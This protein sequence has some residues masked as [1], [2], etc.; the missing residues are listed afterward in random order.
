MEGADFE[1][2]GQPPSTDRRP[3]IAPDRG[4]QHLA[5]TVFRQVF[6]SEASRTFL[7]G[8]SCHHL[9]LNFSK[10]LIDSLP[11]SGLSRGPRNMLAGAKPSASESPIA[12][13]MILSLAFTSFD[14]SLPSET[15][16][17]MLHFFLKSFLHGN[18]CFYDTAPPDFSISFA[19]SPSA[20]HF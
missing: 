2:E 6:P 12:K 9:S 7:S 19:G 3:G 20:T 13:S 17:T 8:S 11:E 14:L 16:E 10:S 4:R 18:P 15:F 5:C 1:D